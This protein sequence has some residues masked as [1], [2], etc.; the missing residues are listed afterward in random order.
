M[1]SIAFKQKYYVATVTIVLE[2]REYVNNVL[3]QRQC[4]AKV[5]AV[6]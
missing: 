2:Q 3:K 5:M 1:V 4:A 6:F